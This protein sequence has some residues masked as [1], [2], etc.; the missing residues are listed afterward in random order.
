MTYI[1]EFEKVHYP[2]PLNFTDDPDN[3]S[4]RKTITRMKNVL[5]M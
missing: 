3:E 1:D 2:L 4:L 5:L